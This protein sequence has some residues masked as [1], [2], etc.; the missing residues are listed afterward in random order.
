MLD[1][2]AL[3]IPR[4]DFIIKHPERFSPHA[5]V[6][7]S[8]VPTKGLVKATYNPTKQEKMEGYKP[9][10]TL[11]KRPY[12]SIWLKI[13]F[14]APKLVFSNNF[15]ELASSDQLSLVIEKLQ[16][17]L[18]KMG[19][20]IK[21]RVL[22]EAKISAI[23]YSKNILLDRTT[24]CYL[25]IQ[26]LEKLDLSSKLDLTQTDFR[27]GG[28]MAKFHASTYEVALY[29][30]V[31]DLEQAK[32]YGDK[33]G[34]ESDY[35]CK[36]DLFANNS[37]PPEVLRIEARLTSRKIKSLFNTLNI[38]VE[39]TLHSLFSPDISRSVLM[40][41]WKIITDGLYLMNIQTDD[42]EQ[43]IHAIKA[44]F[45]NK[46]PAKVMELIGFIYA[47]QKIGARGARLAL[48]LKNHQ[49]YRLKKEAK[50]LNE[51]NLCP[52]FLILSTIKK[53][54]IDF[55]PLERQDIVIEGLI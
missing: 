33:R 35:T 21:D 52:R 11:F 26:T 4:H 41:Y 32:K 13:E 14:S 6:V 39:C 24:P 30:K 17:A 50:T 48:N 43:L 1:T 54:L 10:L 28:Q 44:A 15:E 31:K 27:N 36:I 42:T 38:D 12:N 29:D 3:S 23:H 20:L 19:I 55:I 37:R 40:H 22:E 49:W 46:K 8:S 2:I 34:I 53:D 25:L 45:P 9:R 5:D 16:D 51:N 7:Q 47:C 18:G